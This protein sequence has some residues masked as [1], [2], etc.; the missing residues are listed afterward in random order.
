[1][2]AGNV[3][4][5][6]SLFET[7]LLRLCLLIQALS[8]ARLGDTKGQGI[9]RAL[10]Y[11]RH[12]GIE[13]TRLQLW[14]QV[15]AAL[16]IRNCLMHASGFLTHSRDAKELRRILKSGTF[17]PQKHRKNKGIIQIVET[18]LGQ[19]LQIAN[20]YPWLLSSYLRDFFWDLCQLAKTS[21]SGAIPSGK[22][23]KQREWKK[24]E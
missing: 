19:R 6:V 4:T 11:L 10:E 22:E 9:P 24:S 15:D 8:G 16:K 13:G 7:Y 12:T 5:V 23:G 2:S 17:L 20:E 18:D 21:F 1:M 14:T 3:F